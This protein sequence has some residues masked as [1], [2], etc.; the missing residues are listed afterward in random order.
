MQNNFFQML[1]M[2]KKGNPQ[3]I[4]MNMLQQK[5]GN[6]PILQNVYNM[7]SNGDSAGIEQIARN[8]CK[9][10]GINADEMVSQIQQQMR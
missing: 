3:Q 5:M 4:A 8:L 6:N 7:A 1:S 9:E 2:L 10:K